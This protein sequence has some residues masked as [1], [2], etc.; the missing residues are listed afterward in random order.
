MLATIVPAAGVSVRMQAGKNKAFIELAGMPIIVHTLIALAKCQDVKLV[1]VVVRADELDY[2]QGILDKYKHLFPGLECTVVA[3]GRERQQSVYNALRLVPANTEYVAVHDGAR[4]FI[5]PDVFAACL[6]SAVLNKAA[7]VA[8]PSKDTIKVAAGEYVEGTLERA[9]LRCVQTPQ[10]FDYN[11]LCTAYDQA[12]SSEYLGT[13]DASLVE[14]LGHKVA[15]VNGEYKNIKLT[16]PEDLLIAEA[17]LQQKSNTEELVMRVGQGYDV[18]RLVENRKLILGGVEIPHSLGLLGHSDADVLLHAVKD[19]ILGA[20]GL[21]DIGDHFPDTSSEFK[22]ISSLYLLECVRDII[23]KAGYKVHNVDALIIAE[24]PKV[25]P[26]KE[27]MRVN[28]A[29]ALRIELDAVNLK[30][31]TTEKLGFTGREEGIASSA[32]AMVVKKR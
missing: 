15:L 4:P 25:A 7:I 31:T 30:A 28:I 26:Y 9:R 5:S 11:L 17:Y 18:H 32:V 23:D 2:M 8:V 10:I 20:C 21:G 19:A 14:R 16:T 22:D 6:D 27:Q 3:G 1:Y 29:N 13:D 12:E 24:K